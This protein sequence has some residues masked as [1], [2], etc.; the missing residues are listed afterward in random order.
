VEL[1]H[2]VLGLGALRRLPAEAQGPDHGH[3]KE[4][5][6]RHRQSPRFRRPSARP[7]SRPSALAER[8]AW[9]RIGKSSQ[10]FAKLASGGKG[11]AL[12]QDVDAGGVGWSNPLC[13]AFTAAMPSAT[14]TAGAWQ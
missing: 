5:P 9:S 2:L 7:D 14:P 8:F 3:R 12:L 1:E 11:R 6:S 10:R 13:S 4:A